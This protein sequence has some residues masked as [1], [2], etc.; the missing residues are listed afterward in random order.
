MFSFSFRKLKVVLF[1][2]SQKL[3]E[4]QKQKKT[5]IVL[6]TNIVYYV[7]HWQIPLFKIDKGTEF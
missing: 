2:I 7:Y 5:F 1:H 6:H 3:F 4:S